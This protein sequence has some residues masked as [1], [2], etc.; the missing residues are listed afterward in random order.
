MTAGS[1][2]LVTATLAEHLPIT[3]RL[4][5]AV[6][7]LLRRGKYMVGRHR[8][9][10]PLLLWL[11]PQGRR[12]GITPS[13]NLVIEG[14]PRSG[15]TFAVRA[16]EHVYGDRLRI[17]SH[18]H[19]PSQIDQA[20]T[21]GLPC[22]LVIRPPLDVLASYLIAGPHGLPK[23]VLREYVEYHSDVEA[24]AQNLLVVTFDDVTRHLPR[25]AARI[26][27]RWGFDLEPF[28]LTAADRAAIFDRISE[29]HER[30]HPREPI[31][32]GAGRPSSER[33]ELNARIREVLCEAQ[34]ADALARCD[35]VF[36]RLRV[37]AM[38]VEGEI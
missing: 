14:F 18:A 22:V 9:L 26:S 19:H 16:L 31:E 29:E 36:E 3:T 25:V 2:P 20:I 6:R 30:H 15:N 1:R 32:L 35:A 23:Q 33:H 34:H 38:S 17:A 27:A 8:I 10:L 21:L 11:T 13:T 28:T 4:R 5:F 7:R 12:K 37:R 24:F